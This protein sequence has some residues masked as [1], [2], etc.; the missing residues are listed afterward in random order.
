[1]S[2]SF[3]ETPNSGS[4]TKEPP[5]ITLEYKA[6]GETDR[7]TVM[8]Y[9]ASATPGTA[10]GTA[11]TLYRKDIQV[12]PD[13]WGQYRVSVLYAK[14]DRGKPPV[15]SATFSFDTQGATINIKAAKEHLASYEASGVVAGDFHKGAINVKADGDVEGVDIVIPA[16][17]LTYTF[18]HP[19]GV[20][21]EGYARTLANYTGMTNS[22]VFRGF[23][24]GELLFAGASGSDGSDAE[25]SVTY[26]FIASSNT[27]TLSIGEI[28]GISKAG[29][30]Y[31]WV[32]F[33]DAVSDGE[34]T[35]PP[36]RVHVERVYDVF[37]FASA[38]GW[39]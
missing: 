13:G 22:E 26:N 8:A 12:A 20:V 16:L 18:T 11:G 14:S 9:A 3:E 23:Q 24:I 25:A 38:F 37:N 29:H 34:A 17:K 7:A 15:G 27:T 36:K 39:S 31:A 21:N 6:A 32:E 4:E 10:T 30:D 5:P 33:E 28:T 19:E 2:F 1:M 35:R